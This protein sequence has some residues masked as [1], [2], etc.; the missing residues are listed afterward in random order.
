MKNILFIATI[1]LSILLPSSFSYSDTDTSNSCIATACT[2]TI[3]LLAP[4][5]ITGRTIACAKETL[6]IIFDQSSSCKSVAL[7]GLK[8]Y[9]KGGVFA[10][11]TLYVILF[12]IKIAFSGEPPQTKDLFSFILKFG[13]VLYMCVGTG[14]TDI[15]YKGGTALITGLPNYLMGASTGQFCNYQPSHYED[16]KYAYLLAWDILDCRISHYLVIGLSGIAPAFGVLLPFG[17][18]QIIILLVFSLQI[19]TGLMLLVFGIFILSLAA[20]FLHMTLLAILGL[21][22]LTYA[23]FIFVPMMLF[24]YTEGYFTKWWQGLVSCALQ[25]VIISAFMSLTFLAFDNIMYQGCT[26]Q[27]TTTPDKTF[28]GITTKGKTVWI[29]EAKSGS[30]ESSCKKT[31][32]YQIFNLAKPNLTNESTG[33]LFKFSIFTASFSQMVALLKAGI[34]ALLFCYLFMM[35]AKKGG[36]FASKLTSGPNIGKF[37]VSAGAVIDAAIS[38]LGAKPGGAKNKGSGSQASKSTGSGSKASAG[39]ASGSKASKAARK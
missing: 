4:I 38:K 20:N 6:D 39:K 1:L 22:V 19:V 2:Q 25:P 8:R 14:L 15:V 26:F 30:Q 36:E 37:A 32:G 13:V 28:K 12:G 23:G 17:A 29:P 24:S 7:S 34:Q 27:E 18:L 9:V 3:T 5:S 21:G 35:L 10:A 11:L 31:L 16:S 33:L